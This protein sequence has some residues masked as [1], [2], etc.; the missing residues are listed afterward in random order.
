M[1]ENDYYILDTTNEE[2]LYT[3]LS[4]IFDVERLYLEEYIYEITLKMQLGEI[5]HIDFESFINHIKNR[6]GRNTIKCKVDDVLIHHLTA[7]ISEPK[8]TD[9]LYNLYHSLIQQTDLSEFFRKHEIEFIK[10]GESLLC[11]HKG[12]LVNWED[13]ESSGT[14]AMIKRRLNNKDHCVNGYLLPGTIHKYRNV[15]HLNLYPEILENI[16]RVLKTG[17]YKT[18]WLNKKKTYCIS[19]KAKLNE[20]IIDGK[21]SLNKKEKLTF[22]FECVIYYLVSR[23]RNSEIEEDNNPVIRLNDELNVSYENIVTVQEI[24]R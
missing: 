9:N 1:G 4:K 7:R 3:S 18:E 23:A 14:V 2:T 5:E 11:Y 13:F 20:V 12:N 17:D 15:E 19:F 10:S 16:M 22:I 21:D 6:T 8:Q 24:E